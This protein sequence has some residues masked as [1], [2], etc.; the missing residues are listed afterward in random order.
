MCF[1]LFD[2]IVCN[3]SIV[4]WL[5][6]KKKQKFKFQIMCLS[7]TLRNWST[8]LLSCHERSSLNVRNKLRL[9]SSNQLEIRKVLLKIISKYFDS[10]RAHFPLVN[11]W[12]LDWF[13]FEPIAIKSK[14]QVHSHSKDSWESVLRPHRVFFYATFD[15]TLHATSN[16]VRILKHGPF[17]KQKS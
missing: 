5:I 3:R 11:R 16:Y 8:S 13:G 15:A 10:K 7:A 1:S 12:Q 9:K 14:K 2:P 17:A 6:G 4:F